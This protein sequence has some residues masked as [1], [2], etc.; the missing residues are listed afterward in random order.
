MVGK[1]VAKAVRLAVLQVASLQ[2]VVL[3]GISDS[4]GVEWR[5]YPV[6]VLSAAAVL[7]ASGA[8]EQAERKQSCRPELALAAAVRVFAPEA[9]AAVAAGTLVAAPLL[10]VVADILQLGSLVR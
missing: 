6:L 3:T 4:V 7:S 9:E 10:R 5:K 8:F 2:G 1:V